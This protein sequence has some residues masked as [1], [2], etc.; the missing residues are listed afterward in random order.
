M[1]ITNQLGEPASPLALAAYPDQDAGCVPTAFEAGVNFF[2]FYSLS[3]TV[4]IEG[5]VPL[6]EEH[7]D[8]VIVGTG[9]GSRQEVGLER[10]LSKMLETLGTDHIDI[11]FA[12]YVMPSDDP[13]KI[14]GSGGVLDVLSAWKESG[15]IR[16]V[17][18]S[19]HDR[20]IA[21]RLAEDE[22]VEVLMHRFNMAHRKAADEVFPAA[23][24][25]DVPVVPFTATRWGTLLRGHPDWPDGP[26]K[27]TDCYRYCLDQPAIEIV[28]SAPT[29][30]DEL[31]ENLTVL[32]AS[33]MA[34]EEISRWE[35]YGDLIYGD[36]TDAFETQWP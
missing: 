23:E 10:A 35:R 1:P 21:R 30:L 22:R 27:A 33:P 36:G 17:G 2:F 14:F 4:L 24:K 7:R 15:R 12:E 34:A 26:P 19:A 20:G 13:D 29:T 6:L 31:R 8:R 28:L 3:H 25:A 32:E 11:F 5:L 9:S 18:A 16:Y